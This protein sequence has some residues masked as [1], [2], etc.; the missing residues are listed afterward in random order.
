MWFLLLF[1]TCLFHSILRLLSI[2]AMWCPADSVESLIN[3]YSF[4][5]ERRVVLSVTGDNGELNAVDPAALLQLL[6]TLFC[7][8]RAGLKILVGASL[9]VCLFVCLAFGFGGFALKNC[10]QHFKKMPHWKCHHP[11]EA[12]KNPVCC[13]VL[14]RSTSGNPEVAI[15]VV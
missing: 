2:G 3:I 4:R 13:A 8:C 12:S 14:R 11:W 15:A 9:L 7:L 1:L 5:W 10:E 6:V